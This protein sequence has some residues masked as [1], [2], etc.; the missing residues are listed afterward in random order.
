[1]GSSKSSRGGPSWQKNNTGRGT[2]SY[3][4]GYRQVPYEGTI[5]SGEDQSGR[6]GMPA[7]ARNKSKSGHTPSGNTNP[8]GKS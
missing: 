1:M 4:K 2:E 7:S 6:K 3:S 8:Y 5:M